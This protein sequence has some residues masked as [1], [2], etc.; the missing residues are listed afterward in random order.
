MLQVSFKGPIDGYASA[1]RHGM[2]AAEVLLRWPSERGH[3][4]GA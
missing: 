1:V 4:G 2:E 3:T